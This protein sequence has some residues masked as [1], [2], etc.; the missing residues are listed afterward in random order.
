MCEMMDFKAI[1]PSPRL[2][3]DNGI[4]IAWNGVERFKRNLDIYESK[5]F[6][7]IEPLPMCR[8]GVNYIEKV[9]AASIPCKWVKIPNLIQFTRPGK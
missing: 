9:K 3:T 6:G 4:M 2:C 7:E 1:R 8:L 5:D